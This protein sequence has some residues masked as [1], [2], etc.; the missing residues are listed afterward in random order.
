[1]NDLARASLPIQF[2]AEAAGIVRGTWTQL[3][4][5][6]P[7]GVQ[8]DDVVAMVYPDPPGERLHVT[9]AMLTDAQEVVAERRR[10]DVHRTQPASPRQILSH[11]GVHPCC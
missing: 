11:R 4:A 9:A 6:D 8:E 2:L 7:T 3:E 10:R 5:G 1:M